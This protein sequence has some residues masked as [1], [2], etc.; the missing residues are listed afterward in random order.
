MLSTG[1]IFLKIYYNAIALAVSRGAWFQRRVTLIINGKE[2][3][4]N[5]GSLID[6][7]NTKVIEDQKLDKGKRFWR[8]LVA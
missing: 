8:G 1:N 5:R 7:L 4:F 2:E 3:K 6:F